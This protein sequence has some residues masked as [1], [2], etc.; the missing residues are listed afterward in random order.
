M[1]FE[2]QLTT[3]TCRDKEK[4]RVAF[5]SLSLEIFIAEKKVFS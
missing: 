2:E 5:A 4:L 1:L 3:N